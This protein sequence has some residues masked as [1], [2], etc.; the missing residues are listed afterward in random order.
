MT[1]RSV[2]SSP[3]HRVL[4]MTCICGQQATHGTNC[5]IRE[6]LRTGNVA[7]AGQWACGPNGCAKS[8][9]GARDE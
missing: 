7:L 2:E 9:N 4:V 1:V 3:G 8:N 5:N 6:A